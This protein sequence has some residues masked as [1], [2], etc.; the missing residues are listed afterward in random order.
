MGNLSYIVPTKN[1][2]DINNKKKIVELI[3]ERYPFYTV[4]LDYQF[5]TISICYADDSIMNLYFEEDCYILNFNRD[6]KELK[7]QGEIELAEKLKKLKDT[8]PDLNNTIA[9]THS[10]NRYADKGMK[11][12]I[13]HLLKD[14]FSGYI[15]DEGIHPDYMPPEYKRKPFR[16]EK[17]KP[18]SIFLITMVMFIDIYNWFYNKFRRLKK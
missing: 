18:I 9:S 2:S 1:V 3:K 16:K 14:Y 13:D 8:N 10:T 11:N 12:N 17:I 4:N 6:I 5:D 7:K 15:F